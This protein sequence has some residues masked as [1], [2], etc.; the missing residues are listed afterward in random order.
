MRALLV[1]ALLFVGGGC[2]DF[3]EKEEG[4]VQCCKVC[5]TGKP[6]GDSCI[7]LNTTCRQGPG[8]ACSAAQAEELYQVDDSEAE[9]MEAATT[10]CR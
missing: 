10:V 1:A 6:C 2:C 4:S 7:A 8:C 9:S 3:E 5:E